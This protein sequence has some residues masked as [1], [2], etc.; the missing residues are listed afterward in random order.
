MEA[1]N[2][3]RG[4]YRKITIEF[5]IMFFGNKYKPGLKFP[6]FHVKMESTFDTIKNLGEKI[7]SQW[8]ICMWFYQ[9]L[10]LMSLIIVLPFFS[11]A[12]DLNL[13]CMTSL[14]FETS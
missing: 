7:Q 8:K 2:K 4:I 12:L 1:E 10:L 13:T 3:I 9:K 14:F 6:Q 11:S 5:I